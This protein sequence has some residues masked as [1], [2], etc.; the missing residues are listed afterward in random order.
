MG[1]S[2][3]RGI[4]RPPGYSPAACLHISEPQ[5]LEDWTLWLSTIKIHP[6]QP[7]WVAMEDGRSVPLAKVSSIEDQQQQQPLH[8]G[9]F[10]TKTQWG[11]ERAPRRPRTATCLIR[12]LLLLLLLLL[13]IAVSRQEIP[14]FYVLLGSFFLCSRGHHK[15]SSFMRSVSRSERIARFTIIIY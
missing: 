6:Q 5:W 3:G 10:V 2:R 13:A 1:S 4:K 9:E 15:S 7:H 12:P 11:S 14:H 8:R